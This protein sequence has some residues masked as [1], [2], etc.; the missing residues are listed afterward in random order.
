MKWE[1]VNLGDVLH[2]IIGGG[3][4]SKSK[5]EYWNGDIFWCS[6]KDM[7]DDKHYLSYTKDTITK[8]GLE[9]SSANLI[10]AGTVI[11]STRMGLGRAFINKVDMAINQ[12][13]KA[14]IPNERI[15]NRFLLWTIVSKRNELNMLGRGSTVKGITL[16]ILKSIEIALPPLIVQRRIA[17]ILSAY[18]DLIEN[19]QKQIKLLEEAAMRLYKEWFVNLRFPGYE[20]TKIVDGVPDG[21]SRKKLIDIA[22]IT[23]GQSPKSEYYNDKQQGL[24][25]HQGVTNYGYRFVIDDTYS[26]S[27]TR[28]AE[29]GSILFSVR[30]PVGRMNITKNKI[31][32]GR[33][34][35]AINHREGLQSFLFY[36]LKNRFYK[37]DLIGNGAIYASITK[38]ALHSQEFLIP[39]DNLANKFNSVAKSIDQ[40]ITNA[41]QQ[42]ILLK[43]ARDRLL[44][45]LL[46]G[47]I[48]V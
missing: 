46:S 17:D 45:R 38:S 5:S 48:E 9:N 47:E 33:G 1:T 27:Y 21:W 32:I 22:D 7:E 29:A 6:V 16:D 10:K 24:P 30:A 13:L 18:D 12:D 14:L 11:T 36:M 31:V 20:N 23:M 42:I 15:D 4:P 8:K 39:S 44:P 26:T 35:A 37:D 3:T 2:L 28:I 41:D 34:L 43:Q 40:Q 25:F 19:N